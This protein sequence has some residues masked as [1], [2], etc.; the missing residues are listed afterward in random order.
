MDAETF[1]AAKNGELSLKKKRIE[2]AVSN[3]LTE[4]KQDS[5]GDRKLSEDIGIGLG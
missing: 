5:L 2:S 1:K 4:A 3:K